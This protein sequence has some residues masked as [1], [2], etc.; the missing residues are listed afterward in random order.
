MAPP[1]RKQ[2]AVLESPLNRKRIAAL[3]SPSGAA[4]SLFPAKKQK[5]YNASFFP[6]SKK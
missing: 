4:D 5:Y 3:E 6:D 2:T 1:N